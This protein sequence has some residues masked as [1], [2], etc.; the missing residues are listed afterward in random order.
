M[1]IN[2]DLIVSYSS[3]VIEEALYL[4]TPVALFGND[5][6]RHI[7]LDNHSNNIL[8]KNMPIYSLTRDNFDEKISE[9][10]QNHKNNLNESS[11]DEFCFKYK[12][13]H[14]IEHLKEKIKNL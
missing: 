7:K 11:Y 5:Y 3:T 9:I 12:E 6:F 10:I 4:K 1:I 2:S 13:N 14:Y 8:K